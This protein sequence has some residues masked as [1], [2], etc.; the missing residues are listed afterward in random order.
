MEAKRSLLKS[1]DH[2]TCQKKSASNLLLAEERFLK[3]K[4]AMEEEQNQPEVMQE[5]LLKLMND[6]QVLKSEIPT[7]EEKVKNLVHPKEFEERHTEIFIRFK[8]NG[9]LKI[10]SI[11][12]NRFEE[13]RYVILEEVNDVDQEEKEFDLEDILQIQD[14]ILPEKL[15]NISRLITNIESLNEN[16]T[17]DRVL[18]SPSLV[19]ISVT[20]S[21]SFFEKSDTSFSFRDNSLPE[22]KTFS[23]H[24]EETRSGSTT[25][26]AN[27]SFP[28]DS[29][30][31]KD[32]IPIREG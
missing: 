19:P 32:W 2:H 9:K 1:N 26:H 15:L 6:L 25:T 27:K 5:L 8:P 18:K 30:L 20:D 13:H 17:P 14:V 22:F 23:D 3:I 21:N 7:R 11:D 12:D 10:T 16:P 24:T 28:I 4:Q 29:F 31:I